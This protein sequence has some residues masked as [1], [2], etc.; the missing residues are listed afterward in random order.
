[1]AAWAGLWLASKLRW[2]WQHDRRRESPA[3]GAVVRCPVPLVSQ[4]GPPMTTPKGKETV[5][6][7]TRQGAQIIGPGG[8]PAKLNTVTAE[9]LA[10][11]LNYE[12]LTS[13]DAVDEASTTRLSAVTFYL[14]E[15][16]GWPIEVVDKAT[17]CRDGRMAWVA[18]YFIAPEI[19]ARAMAAGAGDWCAK[20]RTARRARRAHAAQ[21]RRDAERANAARN[22]RRPHPGQQGL[23]EAGF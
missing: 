18:E 1:M 17:G 19:V 7:A 8:L 2:G 12:R 5:S 22:A 11:L 4:G 20:V 9:V 3:A 13:L 15:K 16:Y 6:S 10:R 23:F 21:A 14:A